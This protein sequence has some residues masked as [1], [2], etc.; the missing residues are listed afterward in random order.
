MA[1]ERREHRLALEILYAVDI[2]KAPLDE[3]IAQAKR[4]VGV[5]HRGDIA[6]LDDPWEPA[7]PAVDARSDAPS[8]TDWALVERLVRGTLEEKAALEADYA[9][10][11]ERWTVARLAGIDRLIIDMAAW[12]LRQRDDIDRLEV[13]NHAIEL[14]KRM[15]TEHSGDFVNGILDKIVPVA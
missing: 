10:L 4:G 3:A 9:P 6:A 15:S 11:L 2:G 5:F 7:Y 8:P 1:A 14:A 12:E 13:I